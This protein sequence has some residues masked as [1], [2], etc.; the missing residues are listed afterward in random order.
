[1]ITGYTGEKHNKNLIIEDLFKLEPAYKDY[2]W[3]GTTLKKKYDKNCRLNKVAESWELSAHP[4]GLCRI[5][6]GRFSG[7]T[8]DNF[9]NDVGIQALGKKYSD[10]QEFP[11]LIKF[12]DAQQPLSIQ[13]HPDDIYAEKVEHGQGKTEMWYV[14][15]CEEN[16]FIYYGLKEK[17]SKKEIAERV[18]N[19]SITEILNKVYVHKG[20]AFFVQAGTIHAIG[21]GILICEIQQNSNSTYR[22][23]DYDRR[24]K[25]G[26]TREL[27]LN[28][29]LDVVNVDKADNGCYHHNV[30]KHNGYNTQILAECDYFT[31]IKY[32]VTTT[33]DIKVT[34]DSFVAI[35]IVD[36]FGTVEDNTMA[37]KFKPGDTIF[38]TAG[39]RQITVSGQ[40]L[41]LISHM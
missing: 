17:T 16:A 14:V 20:D 33:A 9:I 34:D 13:I 10:H 31:T 38:A 41:L 28:K 8:F 35:T 26:N 30:R 15:D 11:L 2:L 40:C 22:L 18:K 32:D 7:E 4:D 25:D 1:M 24:D 19:N 29:A 5:A 12:I 6:T 27:Q 36:G 37:I 39:N 23:Y 3:G 21:K